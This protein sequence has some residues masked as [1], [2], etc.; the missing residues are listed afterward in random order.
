MSLFPSSFLVFSGVLCTPND[1]M[2]FSSEGRC[3]DG[4]GIAS[5]AGLC[6]LAFLG[7]VVSLQ[8]YL[9]VAPTAQVHLSLPPA[10]RN[11]LLSAEVSRSF[12]LLLQTLCY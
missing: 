9:Q 8:V 4:E 12:T 6:P 2:R 11:V 10:N 3:H 7:S 1:R 5:K